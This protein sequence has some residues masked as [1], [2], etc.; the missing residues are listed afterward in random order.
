MNRLSYQGQIF[1]LYE[2]S[3]ES[4]FEGDI[5]EYAKEIFGPKS[6]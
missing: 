5:I 2:Y 6:F 1:S 4:D 3:K